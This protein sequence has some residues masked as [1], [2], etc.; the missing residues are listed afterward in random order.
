MKRSK[1]MISIPDDSGAGYNKDG[2][3]TAEVKLGGGDGYDLGRRK[4]ADVVKCC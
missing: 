4:K 2:Q 3:G 1:E